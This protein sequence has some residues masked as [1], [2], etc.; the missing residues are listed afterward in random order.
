MLVHAR[1]PA[2]LVISHVASGAQSV[3]EETRV[4]ALQ[5]EV[6]CPS[7][8]LCLCGAPSSNAFDPRP[9]PGRLLRILSGLHKYKHLPLTMALWTS[10]PPPPRG[11]AFHPPPPR[12]THITPPPLPAVHAC[13][14]APALAPSLIMALMTSSQPLRSGWRRS[15]CYP[16]V[17]R[18][19]GGEGCHSS[20]L[21]RVW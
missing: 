10:S 3:L 21:S 18:G 12:D 16:R 9:P 2:Q 11:H 7:C 14:F 1:W 13:R 5:H 20:Y 17:R 4:S 8:T 19:A 6:L 15:L